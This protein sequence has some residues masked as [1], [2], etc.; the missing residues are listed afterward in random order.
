MAY[1][2]TVW[3]DGQT[4]GASSFNNIENG[5]ANNDERLTKIENG[6]IA[7]IG[8]DRKQTNLFNKFMT[9]LR[10][11]A[12][13]GSDVE[14][15]QLE[16]CFM[17]DSVLWG[18]T[19]NADGIQEDC[20]ADDG[21]MY[22]TRFSKQAPKHSAVRIHNGVISG[23]NAVYGA[24]KVVP[25]L[26]LFSGYCVKWAYEHFYASKSDLIIINFG[27]NDAG[28]GDEDTRGKVESYVDYLRK[29]IEREIS[30][31]TAVVLMTPTPSTMSYGIGA[32]TDDTST[33]VL[34]H[35]Y[36]EAMKQLA[37]EYGCPILD[38]EELVHNLGT[39]GHVDTWHYTQ[40]QNLA[41]GYRIASHFIGRHPMN[42]LTM[43][44]GSYIGVNPQTDGAVIGGLAQY[45]RAT[46]SPNTP[47]IIS[48]NNGV[49]SDDAD[50]KA[51][52]LM[53]N[54]TGNGSIT[55]SF[56][57]PVDGMVVVPSVYTK[58][59]NQGVSMQ[60]D[61]GGEQGKWANYWNCVSATATPDREYKEPSVVEIPYTAMETMGEGKA[62]GL[63]ML[64]HTDQP[65]LKITSKGW[66]TV[67]LMMPTVAQSMVYDDNEIMPTSV[68]SQ[69][70]GDGNFDVFGLNFLSLNDYKRMVTERR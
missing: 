21:D 63:H 42:P 51:K 26:K 3:Q 64:Q 44:N 49:P 53:V 60:L 15:T 33:Y 20:T 41:I 34:I 19:P 17:G 46:Y 61:F 56:Y 55:W 31:G 28:W 70:V 14:N 57:C 16:I 5:I 9:N 65:V 43:Y 59:T 12:Y 68:P 67:S 45:S 48:G 7:T 69:P 11:V 66:H 58:T 36:G 4:Y 37:R 54:V 10:T 8:F 6:E 1:N 2:K 25:K 13:N 35:A 22:S 32:T 40:E 62:Y 38:G 47:E 18:Y 39:A 24:N 27:I 52:G 29:I 50:Y 30:N 23:L